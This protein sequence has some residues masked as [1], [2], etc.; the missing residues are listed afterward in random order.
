V[1]FHDDTPWNCQVAVLNFDH[2][3]SDKVRGQHS[4]YGTGKFLTSWECNANGDLV[5]SL[6]QPF[7]PLLQELTY[8]RP[9]VF[10]S[11]AAFMNGTNSHPDTH[12]SCLEETFGAEAYAS[13][14]VKC[15]GLQAP[16]GTGPLKYHSRDYLDPGANTTDKRV[17]FAAHT[18]YWGTVPGFDFVEV[19]HFES[20]ALVEAA[21]RDGTLDMVLGS[22]PL[23]AKQVV[24]IEQ[25]E[26]ATFEVHHSDVFQ[27]AVLV[28]NTGRV[29]TN[30]I[31]TRQAMIHAINKA[32]M[33]DSELSDLEQ[34]VTQLLPYSAPYCNVDLNPKWSY[35]LGTLREKC[36]VSFSFCKQCQPHVRSC[37]CPC[38]TCEPTAF[39][40]KAQFLNCPRPTGNK[41]ST[42][43]KV[44]ISIAGLV[45]VLLATVLAKM[46]Y[47]EKEG[48]PI[49]SPVRS[50]SGKGGDEPEETEVA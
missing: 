46:V 36:F 24:T 47:R 2:V 23:T 25:E 9:L 12:N 42:G 26:S 5:L 22:G 10:A 19:R 48:K 45:I 40:E 30:D 32:P 21:L 6:S 34:P 33:I 14:N 7:Y 20:T 28:L 11:A 31:A 18:K 27:H 16:I 35:D 29:P 13:A 49:F 39:T 37:A 4:W 38:H 44:G 17:V 15:V 1:L 8:S 43:A 50:G 41:L 3:L